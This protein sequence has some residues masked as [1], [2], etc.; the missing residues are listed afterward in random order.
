M[1]CAELSVAVEDYGVSFGCEPVFVGIATDACD[2][3]EGEVEGGGGEPGAREEGDQEGSEAAVYVEGESALF[4]EGEAGE[5]GD[6]VDDAVGEV[7]GGTDEE[8]GVAIYEGGHGGG[9]DLV[10]WGRA[11]DEVDFDAE[12]GAGFAEGSVGCFGDDPVVCQHGFQ[13]SAL[14]D[15][16]HISGSVTPRSTL[17]FSLALRHAMR[18]DSVPPLVV[19][20]AAPDGALNMSKTIATISAS[21]FRT[22]GKTSGCIGLATL[23]LLNAST[24]SSINSSPP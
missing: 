15:K 23:N 4:A 24:C 13:G 10:G 17:P 19:T 9:V 7:G 3:F 11:G 8:D 18:M 2:A 16:P 21:I 20:P 1:V 22:P 6:V 14:G 12:V 5:G